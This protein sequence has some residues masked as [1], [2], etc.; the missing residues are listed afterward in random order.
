VSDARPAPAAGPGT[1]APVNGRP[2]PSEDPFRR[3]LAHARSGHWARAA[4]A[5][6]AAADDAQRDPVIWLNLAHACLKLGEFER[7]ADAACRAMALDP[8]SELG[9]NIAATCLGRMERHRDLVQ[10]FESI[11]MGAVQDPGLHLQLGV[12]LSRL[13]RYQ[14]AVKALFDVLRRDP[15]CAAAF[16]Q[17]GNVF[18]FLRMPEEARESFRNACALGR[19]PVEMLAAIVYTSLEASRWDDL[20]A[21]LAALERD[22]A[23]GKGQP[24]PFFCLN[25]SWTRT[26]QLAAARAQA[27]A[28]AQGSAP[29]AARSARPAHAPIRI[30]YVSG[31]L[32]EHAT[33]YLIADVFER[34][35]CERFKIHAY[36]YGD[37]DGSPMRRR[38]E[39]AFGGNFV[40]A[41]EMPSA[42]LARRIR[43]DGIDVLFDLK[44]YT[45]HARSDIFAYRAAPIQVNYLGYP[46][47]L[48]SAHYDYII[49]DPIVTP[50]AHADGYAEMIA[51]LP[52]CY[53]PNDRH[54]P[55]GPPAARAECGLPQDAFVFCC[56]NANYKITPQVFDRW[57]ALLRRIDGA[58][59]WLY[60][61]NAQARRNLSAEAQRRG[62]DPARLFWAATL[63][64]AQHLQRIQA[65]DLFL[66]TWP[67]N[68]H[69]TASDAL[70]AGVPV[71][72]VLGETFAARV[73]ASL[74]ES[75]GLPELVARDVD[76]YE[77]L[78][79]EL[80]RD[81]PRL[82]A[83]RQRLARNRD[84]CALF[85]SARY[86]RDFEALIE[87]MMERQDRGLPP[88]HLA[89]PVR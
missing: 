25:F 55:L 32:R 75:A 62:I 79:I 67:V 11:D 51:Q 69:T 29:L 45:L 44:G 66:D 40:E 8:S 31:D 47:S 78:A 46:G 56:F 85:D 37:D 27:A 6:A 14:D 22:V 5:F 77:R 74:L 16:A 76:A 52:N 4:G 12:A 84:T 34:H 61:A 81:R 42:A 50:C 3:G 21:D 57:C 15:R 38:I 58:V 88:E 19:S 59:L 64:L 89:A 18:Q 10:L 73:A 72:T 13:E 43:S 49:G 17:L 24:A 36:S 20:D 26:Q 30:G 87:R 83:L 39:T 53:Q 68:A 2:H 54:R 41:R 7:G 80:A 82:A 48:G 33:A 65:A 86:T 60:V 63:P 23:A 70:W 35:D 28:V 9:L 1:R 71:L